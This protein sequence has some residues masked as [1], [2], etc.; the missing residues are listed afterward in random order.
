M[1]LG[2]GG[3]PLQDSNNIIFCCQSLILG[4]LL[5][6]WGTYLFRINDET[7]GEKAVT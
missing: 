5:I 4:P 1:E 2:D 7:N 6:V 3:A